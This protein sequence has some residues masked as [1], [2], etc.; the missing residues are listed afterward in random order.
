MKSLFSIAALAAVALG[1]KLEAS[2]SDSAQVV[3]DYSG[4]SY[5]ITLDTSAGTATGT[6]G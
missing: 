5:P 4:K 3:I 6:N 1:V 2:A